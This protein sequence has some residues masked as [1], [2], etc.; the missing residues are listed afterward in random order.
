MKMKICYAQ[1]GEYAKCGLRANPKTSAI[2]V[3]NKVSA[4][5]CS[6]C[7]VIIKNGVD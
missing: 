7:L 4:V 3:S 1:I 2:L 6:D 5:T